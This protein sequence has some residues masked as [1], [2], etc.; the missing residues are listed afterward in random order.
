MNRIVALVTLL[1]LAA[2]VLGATTVGAQDDV[3]TVTV[4]VTDVDGEDVRGATVT[5][6][7]DDQ[8]QT[9]T[10]RSNGQALFDVSHGATITV[11][12]E[13]DGLVRNKPERVSNVEESRTV[14]VEMHPAG[15]ATITVS[16][17]G[18][19]LE[20]ATVTFRKY[21]QSVRAAEGTAGADGVVSAAEIERGDYEVTVER[22]GYYGEEI[23]LTVGEDAAAEVAVESGDV[24]VEFTVV[25]EHF[26]EPRPQ[27]AEI[28]ILADGDRVAA[29]TTNDRGQR[30]LDLAV[31]TEY[32]IVVESDGYE[33]LETK[34]TVGEEDREVT[35]DIRRTDALTVEPLN[36]RVVVGQSVRLEVV[37]EY[38]EP[39]VG[40]DVLVDGSA[41]TTTDEDGAATV[42]IDRT[43]DVE[44]TAEADGVSSAV[45]VV[46]GVS[47]DGEATETATDES[48]DTATEDEPEATSTEEAEETDTETPDEAGVDA[49]DD[50][51][52]GFTA[53]VAVAALALA[54]IALRRR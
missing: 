10:T 18:A 19:P 21:G 27:P 22:P 16:D 4:H 11:E 52:P 28:T 25:D 40:A 33:T 42:E 5:V 43:G 15:N 24:D 20:G 12:T 38:D 37:D 3:V 51:S 29:I 6:S 53:L 14:P 41:V 7:H 45:A 31:N 1:V 32:D 50:G 44:I 2:P 39:V 26:E 8:E 49:G 30:G 23:D 9:D 34:L 46:E 13:A 54:T 36:D 35:Y 17:E 48:E 47:P